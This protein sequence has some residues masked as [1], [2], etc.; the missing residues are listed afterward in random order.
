MVNLNIRYPK[1]KGQITLTQFVI[2]QQKCFA[3]ISSDITFLLS[4]IAIACK[5]IS[6]T[7]NRGSINNILGNARTENIQG[8]IQK[9]LDI[10]TNEI[11]IDALKSTGHLSGMVSEEV[12]SPISIPKQ[13]R[14][15]KYLALFDPLDG[16]SNIDVNITVGTIFSILKVQEGT[17]TNPDSFL[18]KGIKLVKL[19]FLYSF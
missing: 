5:R 6:H 9:Q 7:V 11:M 13:F 3:E 15:G 16:S 18:Q 4:D 8:E 19:I 12:D 14:K 10:I 2:E 1:M 17:N